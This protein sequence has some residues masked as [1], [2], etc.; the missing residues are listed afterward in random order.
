MLAIWVWFALRVTPHLPEPGMKIRPLPFAWGQYHQVGMTVVA[1]PFAPRW[2]V[3]HEFCHHL[4]HA[5]D[6]EHSPTG[7]AFLQAV[8]R[9]SWDYT[10]K[11]QFA[12]TLCGMLTGVWRGCPRKGAASTLKPLL[13]KG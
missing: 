3:V 12:A 9:P 1:Q 5:A 4:W 2:A 8:G 11:E 7:G 6:I 10:A 13:L